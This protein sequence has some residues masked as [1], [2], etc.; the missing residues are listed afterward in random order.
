MPT[1]TYEG[2]PDRYYPTLALTPDPGAQYEL[3]A[4]PGDGRWTPPDPAPAPEPTAPPT[5]R[6]AKTAPAPAPAA[7]TDTPKAGE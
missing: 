1:Y 5:P 6:A 4:N 7:P 3:A 2:E